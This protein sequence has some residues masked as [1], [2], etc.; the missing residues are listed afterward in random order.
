MNVSTILIVD[1]SRMSR[2]LIS[3]IAG[4]IYPDA[5]L[6]EAED[7]ADALGKIAGKTVDLAT[8]D[9]NMPG[10]MDGLE[11]ARQVLAMCPQARVGLLT[12]TLEDEIAD[13]VTRLGIEFVGKP[14]TEDSLGA[15]LKN[16]P[17]P[18]T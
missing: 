8:I 18:M 16:E 6:I 3:A 13:E 11:L 5:E 7:G 1:D 10:G 15:F 14:I 12:A 9:Y 2:M 4:D 17:L